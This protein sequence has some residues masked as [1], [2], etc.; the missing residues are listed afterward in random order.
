MTLTLDERTERRAALIQKW[1]TDY[2]ITEKTADELREYISQF[3][4]IQREEFNGASIHFYITLRIDK[5]NRQR[6]DAETYMLKNYGN[7]PAEML[8][9]DF[10]NYRLSF[11]RV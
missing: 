4:I 9:T 1:G 3:W 10:T 6:Y 11:C 2:W 7:G 5:T 8:A